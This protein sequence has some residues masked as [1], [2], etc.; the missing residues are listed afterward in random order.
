M[1]WLSVLCSGLL[2]WSAVSLPN[3]GDVVQAGVVKLHSGQF[4]QLDLAYKDQDHSLLF[5]IFLEAGGTT[6]LLCGI[7][8]CVCSLYSLLPMLSLSRLGGVHRWLEPRLHRS[9]QASL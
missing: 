2:D 4:V 8:A 9:L 5:W 7:L 3:V 1:P 6:T